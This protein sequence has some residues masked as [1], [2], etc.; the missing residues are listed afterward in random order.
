LESYS[1][2]LQG[3][4]KAGLI[5]LEERLDRR[6]GDR[7]WK[8]RLIEDECHPTVQ[9]EF[10]EAKEILVDPLVRRAIR[11]DADPKI[12]TFEQYAE[13]RHLD[14]RFFRGRLRSRRPVS[15]PVLFCESAFHKALT[16]APGDPRI[17]EHLQDYTRLKEQRSALHRNVLLELKSHIQEK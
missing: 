4:A 9:L 1:A 2:A 5:P 16:F 8:H 6:F 3:A 7:D 12:S 14:A 17:M 11:Y 10:E 15:H 13:A